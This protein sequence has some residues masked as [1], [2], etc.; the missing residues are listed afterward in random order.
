MMDL[1]YVSVTAAFFAL[2]LAYVHGCEQLGRQ[3]QGVDHFL[4]HAGRLF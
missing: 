3:P 2:M 1:I 4:V